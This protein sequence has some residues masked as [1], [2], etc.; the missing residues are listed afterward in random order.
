M[1]KKYMIPNFDNFTNTKMVLIPVLF[2]SN[3]PKIAVKSARN[4]IFIK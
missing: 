4:I 3:M 2:R 1:K